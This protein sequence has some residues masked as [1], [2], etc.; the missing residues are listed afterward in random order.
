MVPGAKFLK[1]NTYFRKEVNS[2][3]VKEDE[4]EDG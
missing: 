3:K 1:G 4:K 2:D